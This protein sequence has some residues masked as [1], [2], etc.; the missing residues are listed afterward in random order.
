[1]TGDRAALQS[2]TTVTAYLGNKQ[3]LLF[4]LIFNSDKSSLQR[5]TEVTVY[6]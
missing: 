5:Q 2:Q 1:M 4:V 6:F 3:L